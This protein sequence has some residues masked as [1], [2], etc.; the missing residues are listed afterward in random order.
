MEADWEVEV[1]GGSPVIE[2]QWDGFVDLHGSPERA[3]ELEEAVQFPALAEILV[4]LNSTASPVWTSKCDVWQVTEFDPDELD[5]PPA[6]AH[7]GMAC[8]ID[9]LARDKRWPTPAA[10]T[11]WCKELCGRIGTV[12][13]R[14]ARVDLIVREAVDS[15]EAAVVGVTAYMTACGAESREAAAA[16]GSSLAA[17][18]DS[19]LGAGPPA[20]GASK[21]Q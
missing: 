8:Y 14:C 7:Y 11:E 18:A 12:P 16:L 20:A 15:E 21:L 9:L 5:A 6:R 19:V 10:A 13:V 1:G 3:I 2:V 17:L 4:G